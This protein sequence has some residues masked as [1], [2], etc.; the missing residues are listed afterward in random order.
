[1]SVAENDELGCIVVLCQRLWQRTWKY[2][3]W[4]FSATGNWPLWMVT[5]T[6]KSNIW[7]CCIGFGRIVHYFLM[8]PWQGTN[9]NDESAFSA[10]TVW[11][12]TP[13]C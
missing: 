9:N 10:M 4:L 6:R 12:R 5:D 8:N 7:Y 13:F 11:Q 3:I 2:A 1:M